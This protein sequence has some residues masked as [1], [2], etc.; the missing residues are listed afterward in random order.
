L[1]KQAAQASKNGMAPNRLHQLQA[2]L[3]VIQTCQSFAV[4][5]KQAFRNLMHQDWI[6]CK[7]ESIRSTVGEIF[8]VAASN[9]KKA[10]KSAID[11]ALLPPFHINADLWTSKVTGEKFLGVRVFWKVGKVLKSALLAVTAYNP[12][13]IED[14]GASE[15]LLEYIL[16]VLRWYGVRAADVSGAKSIGG[17]LFCDTA[18]VQYVLPCPGVFALVARDTSQQHCS[19]G[20]RAPLFVDAH[21]EH[22]GEIA[23]LQP[24]CSAAREKPFRR[25]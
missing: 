14:K 10:I 20:H 9:V 16:A 21:P 13:K 25:G 17:G 3:F 12:P 2:A 1:Q 24:R 15:W 8:L 6:P 23:N 5:E 18:G 11:V 22:A 19:S 7:A 4:V